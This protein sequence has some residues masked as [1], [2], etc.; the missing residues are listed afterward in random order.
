MN[1]K[2]LIFTIAVFLLMVLG[3]SQ[4]LAQSVTVDLKDLPPGAAQA[5]IES[6]KKAPTTAETVSGWAGIGKEIGEAISTGLMSVVGAADKFGN[7]QVG[8]FTMAMIAFSIL[9]KPIM[10]FILEILVSVLIITI[11]RKL[12]LK[13][14]VVIKTEGWFRKK[15]YEYLDPVFDSGESGV[16]LFIA[17]IVWAGLTAIILTQGFQ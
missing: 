14:K 12:I 6:T 17:A 15:E 16:Y 2:G 13:R 8:Y 3:L 10:A 4:L 1:W 7:T 11:S 9:G 5:V